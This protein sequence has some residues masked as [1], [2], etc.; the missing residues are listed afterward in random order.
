MTRFKK[1]S[2]RRCSPSDA[3]E[4]SQ[5]H[6]RTRVITIL[7]VQT[8]RQWSALSFPCDALPKFK[9][10]RSIQDGRYVFCMSARICSTTSYVMIPC[11][12][13][14]YSLE[15]K[16]NS[17][18]SLFRMGGIFKASTECASVYHSKVSG[19]PD[20]ADN[21]CTDTYPAKKCLSIVDFSQLCR[22]LDI[23]QLR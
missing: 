3:T 14:S 10:G 2:S 7:M 17:D 23:V 9:G 11:F 6:K 5:L 12:E 8:V 18:V 19:M 16:W 4:D 22:G 21:T 13:R 1:L 15:A 20:S